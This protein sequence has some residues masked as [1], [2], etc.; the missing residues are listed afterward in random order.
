MRIACDPSQ[1]LPKEH[2][3]KANLGSISNSKSWKQFLLPLDSTTNNGLNLPALFSVNFLFHASRFE[4]EYIYWCLFLGRRFSSWTAAKSNFILLVDFFLPPS[5][6]CFTT[7]TKLLNHLRVLPLPPF[8][9][10]NG[11]NWGF[12]LFKH[13]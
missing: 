1:T 2:T 5:W 8:H 6:I 4:A 3:K 12:I 11:N 7:Q 10:H 13:Y 9:R